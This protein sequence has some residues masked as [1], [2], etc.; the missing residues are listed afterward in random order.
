MAY[1]DWNPAYDTGVPGIDY[2]HR[3]LVALLNEI[4]EL[5]ANGAS[6]HKIAGTLGDFHARAAAHFALEEKIM[7][8]RDFP[9]LL[10]RQ[11]THYRLLDQV[12]EI[13]EGYEVGSYGAGANLPETLRGW[14]LEAMSI[15]VKLFAGIEETN[16]RAWGLNRA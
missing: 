1:L 13:M 15:D 10:E 16:L 5:I 4:H 8:D 3:R 2:E 9:A 7:R 11:D 6:A 14:L 12:R